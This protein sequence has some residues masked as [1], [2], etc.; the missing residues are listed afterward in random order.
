MSAVNDWIVRE[1]FEA[2]GFLV[3]QP[4]KYQVL[5]RS[6]RPDEEMDLIAF[7]P[8]ASGKPP[9]PG[10][11]GAAEVKHVRAAVVGIHGWHTKRISAA[12][13]DLYPEL[14]RFAEDDVARQAERLLG[15]GPV[16]RILCLPELPASVDMRTRTLEKIRQRGVDGVLVFRTILLELSAMTD[17]N[18]LYEKSDILQLLRILKTYGLLRGAQMELFKPQPRRARRPG[19]DEEPPAGA[20]RAD[21][22]PGAAAE[23]AT[24]PPAGEAP[25]AG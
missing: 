23:A 10:L 6:K 7:N 14:F 13:V 17:V 24:P 8:H 20:E 18:R 4:H 2:L 5:S 25:P 3:Q 21:E 1:Y 22:E 19:G 11:W 9:P 16:T 15:R 12:E